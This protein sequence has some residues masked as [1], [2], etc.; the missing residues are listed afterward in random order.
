MPTL[1]APEK[2]MMRM[3]SKGVVPVMEIVMGVPALHVLEGE[4]SA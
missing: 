2:P 1:V 3:P 4:T